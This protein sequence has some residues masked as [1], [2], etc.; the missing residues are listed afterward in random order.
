[1]K[2]LHFDYDMEIKYS[3]LISRCF[4]TIKCIPNDSKMQKII[5]HKVALYPSVPY[6]EGTDSF[7]NKQIYGEENMPHDLFSFHVSGDVLVGLSDYDLVRDE[8]IYLFRNPYGLNKPGNALRNY[9]AEIELDKSKS[10]LEQSIFL[11]HKLHQD[12]MYTKNI[13]T[14]STTAEEAY[15]L[16][17]GVCQ[18]YAHILIALLHMAEIPARYVAGMLVGEGASHAWVEIAQD[19]KWYPIDP[20]NDCIV[21][22]AHIK[23]GVGRDAKDCLINRGIVRGGGTQIQ[24]VSVSVKET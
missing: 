16:G 6:S 22:D 7:G 17:Q 11:M 19:G 14:M 21:K 15:V 10:A 8:E 24:T 1:M 3:E 20:T 5:R 23:I 12:F 18:D 9:F 2:S 13:T 4:F